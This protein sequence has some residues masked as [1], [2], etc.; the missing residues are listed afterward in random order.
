[1]PTMA[2]A[3]VGTMWDQSILQKQDVLLFTNLYDRWNPSSGEML[4]S[5]SSAH[6]IVSL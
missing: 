6:Y 4:F 3:I 2:K 1:M 5:D